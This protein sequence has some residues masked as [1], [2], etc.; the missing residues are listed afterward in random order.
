MRLR[1]SLPLVLLAAVLSQS[2]AGGVFVRAHECQIVSESPARYRLWFYIFKTHVFP[3]FCQMRVVPVSWNGSQIQ[4]IVACRGP[5]A[6]PC[7]VQ[8]DGSALYQPSACIP[9]WSMFMDSLWIE[10]EGVPAYFDAIID[11]DDPYYVHADLVEFPC[12]N[13][14]GIEPGPGPG[15]VRL[16]IAPNPAQI[17][18]DVVFAQP[19]DGPVRISVFDMTGRRMRSLA[20]RLYPAGE[21]RVAWDLRDDAGRDVPTGVYRVRLEVGGRRL[22]RSVLRLR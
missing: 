12:A 1:L 15:E 17:S 13:P 14:V 16:A 3:A 20:D 10:V 9:Q 6:L 4:P 19:R 2:A 22:T 18:S 8:P 11:S 5:S 7:S 21:H